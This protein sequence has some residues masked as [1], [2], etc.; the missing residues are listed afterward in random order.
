MQSGAKRWHAA[1]DQFVDDWIG[2]T[3][4]RPRVALEGFIQSDGCAWCGIQSDAESQCECSGRRLQWSRVFRLGT[5]G[6]PL[7]TCI[8][9]GKYMAWP[10]ML[11][12][13]GTMLGERIKG[14]VPPKSV[15]VPVPMHP[16]RRLFRR[17][18]HT[19][20]IARYVARAS[21]LSYRKL[22]SR[23]N[24]TPQA[25]LTA[26]GRKALKRNSMRRRR[27]ARV[28]GRS[29]ILIDDVLTTGRTLEVAAHTLRTAG[30]ISVIVAVLAVT[31]MPRKAKNCGLSQ[32]RP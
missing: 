1:F 22:L 13:L 14:C 2:L 23:K 19:D 20:V 21:K 25:A 9:Q 29:V 3:L 31:D 30:A 26:T 8:L 18:D 24:A 17:I 5:Y 28:Q 4:P 6:P 15:V 10:E 11:E 32:Q 7:S 27:L 16:M 12:L